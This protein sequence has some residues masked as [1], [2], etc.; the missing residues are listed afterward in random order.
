MTS[1]P[2]VSDAFSQ[3]SNRRKRAQPPE[4]RDPPDLTRLGALVFMHLGCLGV[5]WV[6]FSPIAFSL[7]ALFYFTRA[8]A[9]TA[10]YHRYFSHRAFKT[11][12]WF[13][14]AGAFLGSTAMQK[15]PLWWAAHHRD[16]HRF[17]D[18]EGD[19]HSPHV[20]GFSWSHMGWFLTRANNELRSA[21]VRDWLKYPELRYLDRY[22]AF[23]ALVFAAGLYAL[24]EILRSVGPV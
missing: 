6:G 8:F 17:A 1:A 15:G 19:V 7:A 2:F 16:H 24:G 20:H 22:A 3:V 11:S 14:F 12:R 10:F 18:R 23:V 21:L 13:Q 4:Y 5:F 9:L